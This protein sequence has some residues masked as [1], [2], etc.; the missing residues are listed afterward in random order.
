MERVR[1][2]L[3]GLGTVGASFYELL[4]G[5]AAEIG[6]RLG[7]AIEVPVVAVR[8]PSRPRAVG[9][10]T[11]VVGGPREILDDP[12][13]AI[14]VEL[15]GGTG[16]AREVVRGALERGKHVI[17]ANKALLAAHGE[18]LFALARSKGVEL[19]FEASV[20]GGIPIVKV[21]RESLLG[22][23][24]S[25][26][27]GIVNGTTNY[28]LTRMSEEGLGY[29]EALAA[30][31]AKGFAEA[32]PAADVSGADAAQ[33]IAILASVAFGSWVDWRAVLCEGITKVTPRDIDFAR[34]AGYVFKLVAAATLVEGRPLVTVYPAMVPVD[35]PL[36]AVRGEFNAVMVDSDF[37]GPVGLLG[38]GR[39]RPAHGLVARLGPRRPGADPRG[40]A[41]GPAA[42]AGL[43]AARALPR[44]SPA[45]PL[46][47]PLRHRQPA[48]HLGARDGH[49]GG[50]RHQHRERAPE[51]GGPDPAVRPV[52]ARRRGGGRP[53]AEGAR[54]G[55]GLPG[56]LGRVA[57]LQDPRRG[58]ATMIDLHT[59][60]FAS[61]GVLCPAE[62][63]RR[64]EAAGLAAIAITD[65]ADAS[66]LERLVRETV[67][68]VRE[69]QPYLRIRVARRHRAHPRAA[70]PGGGPRAPRPA[71]SAR[72]SW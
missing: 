68:F 63:A 34:S 70:G 66:N 23:R 65:H 29:A 1:I 61:D 14:V 21:L 44:R 71:S 52:R 19:L 3:V 62:L 18:E 32:D 17:T 22:N 57:L 31:Q 59:H 42:D 37:L 30:A 8:D 39:R 47:L 33:K 4:T 46:L 35:H 28:I 60:T 49:A 67:T 51:V 48:R 12:S 27:L 25:R 24:V 26:I 13:L 20:C 6:R 72:R 50:Q 45:L 5:N 41:R 2:G 36:A 64:A 56:H 43:R 15:V 69:T 10:A 58:A 54:A 40:R 55:V 7:V 11:R 53:A 16:V 38:P 9:P